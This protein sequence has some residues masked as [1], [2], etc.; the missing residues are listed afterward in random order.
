VTP[1]EAEMI[2][3]AV[4]CKRAM[5]KQREQKQSAWGIGLLVI[6]AAGALAWM[7]HTH[8]FNLVDIATCGDSWAKADWS[9]GP[10]VSRLVTCV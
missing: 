6:I 10:R 8:V 2:A 5:R 4:E 7:C 1:Q 3:E 9:L